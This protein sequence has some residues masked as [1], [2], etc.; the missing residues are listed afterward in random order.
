MDGTDTYANAT[1]LPTATE[2]IN[3]TAKITIPNGVKLTCKGPI[4][5]T[6]DV[7][8]DC[9][10]SDSG[11][12][13]D[14]GSSPGGGAASY[15]YFFGNITTQ[16]TGTLIATWTGTGRPYIRAKSGTTY[17]SIQAA[18]QTSTSGN[19][20]F[21]INGVK[22]SNLGA[23][24]VPAVNI[25]CNAASFNQQLT[26]VIFDADCRELRINGIVATSG[27]ILNRVSF[28]QTSGNTYV[29]RQCC[30]SFECAADASTG[31]RTCEDC[32]FEVLP[33]ALAKGGATYTACYFNDVWANN[34]TGIGGT[35]TSSYTLS[36]CFA[37]KLING[38]DTMDLNGNTNDN[39]LYIDN[40]T[41]PTTT[42]LN[43]H[44]L[45]CVANGV[46]TTRT[47]ERWTIEYNMDD[48]SGDMFKS[49]AGAGTIELLNNLIVPNR[50]NKSTGTIFTFP[51]NPNSAFRLRCDH[52]TY[53]GGPYSL[54]TSEGGLQPSGTIASIRSNLVYSID[55]TS[56]LRYVVSKADGNGAGDT[57]DIVPAS[58]CSHNGYWNLLSSGNAGTVYNIRCTGTPGAND[59]DLGDSAGA[60]VSTNGPKFV[61][62]T[63][64]FISWAVNEVGATGTDSFK[65]SMGLNALKAIS[66][67]TSL[68]H[69]SGLEMDAPATYVRAGFAPTNSLL[70]GTAH[71]G[72]TIGAID[73]FE[74]GVSVRR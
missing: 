26:D 13:F 55:G 2:A 6:A 64:K 72:G 59:V 1:A 23:S 27:W 12:E 52:N 33:P 48:D 20:R 58:G 60:S 18:S 43:P 71:D 19:V 17:A 28:R 32:T 21:N 67:T 42:D 5:T 50:A 36:R 3:A 63:R 70:D 69:I 46:G 57:L 7:Q 39:Y 44:G 66:D 54:S 65:I 53:I 49:P 61:D 74:S 68:N 40:V 24:G 47:H 22:F 73:F 8:I 14:A 38:I 34:S 41:G 35:A 62:P 37:R 15:R 25:F 31:T 11:I 4:T 30:A 45:G 16:G 51:N 10:S 29:S 56:S 9:T